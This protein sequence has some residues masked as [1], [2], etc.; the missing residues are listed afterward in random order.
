M[1]FLVSAALIFTFS[2]ITRAG[3]VPPVANAP[4]RICAF[5]VRVFGVTKMGKDQVVDILVKTFVRYDLVLMQEIRDNTDTAFYELFNRLND[6]ISKENGAYGDLFSYVISDKLGRS[7]SK[8]QYA[9]LYRQNLLNVVE[10]YQYPDYEDYFER[11]PYSVLLHSPTT[12]IEY[13]AV[14]ALHSKPT[15]AVEEVDNIT[16]VYDILT[17]RWGLQDVLVAGDLNSDCEYLPDREHARIGLFHDSRFQWLIGDDVDTTTTHSEC[18]YDRFI[19]GGL[20]LRAA[21]VPNSAN[22]FQFDTAFSLSPSQAGEVS[23]HYPIEMELSGKP[24]LE[25][26]DRVKD[27]KAVVIESKVPVGSKYDI[28]DMK[29]D[30]PWSVGDIREYEMKT[31]L[32]GTRQYLISAVL[33][34]IPTF[35]QTVAELADLQEQYPL[36]FTAEM[37]SLVLAMMGS[38]SFQ[39]DYVYGL[40]IRFTSLYRIELSCILDTL[41]CTMKVEKQLQ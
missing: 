39:T 41:I 17:S 1:R 28:R 6:K 22:I 16:R 2:Y 10:T 32:D 15:M 18:S 21:V 24:N 38:A 36:L 30:P 40:R 37:E 26:Q 5:N 25:L 14:M 34:N 35:D 27:S 13:F 19:A 4:L 9:F 12:D 29:Y 31:L 23:D 3:V 20:D 33:D 7:T 11:P 8:E